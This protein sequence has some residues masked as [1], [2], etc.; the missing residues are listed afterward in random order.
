MVSCAFTR[1]CWRPRRCSRGT[2]QGNLR[3]PR[4]APGQHLGVSRDGESAPAFDGHHVAIYLADFSGPY[5]RLLERGPGTQES[6]QHQYRFQ[7]IVDLG[8][9][10]G[11]V[12]SSSTRSQHA[13]PDVCAAAGQPQRGA[14]NRASR[15]DT[16]TRAGR[17]RLTGE[18]AEDWRPRPDRDVPLWN[19]G[20][21]P[22][23]ADWRMQAHQKER[24]KDL[25]TAD[26]SSPRLDLSQSSFVRSNA[27]SSASPRQCEASRWVLLDEG[28]GSFLLPDLSS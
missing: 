28:I 1:G 9:W 6:D 12:H 14:T 18:R 17:C 3:T 8:R 5:R 23:L 4:S 25:C 7:D 11:V 16:N 15:R 19:V 24:V 21:K 22:L 2:Y 26:G 20:L 13:P 27:P 10:P